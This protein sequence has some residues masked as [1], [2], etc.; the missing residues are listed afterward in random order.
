MTKKSS[1]IQIII[2]TAFICVL[3]VLNLILPDVEFSEQEN[4][5]LAQ[6][7][8]FSFSA[9]FSGKFMDKFESY[10]T[11]QFAF[12]DSWTTMKAGCE[13]A[14]GKKENKGVYLCSDGSLIERYTAPDKGLLETNIS[15]VHS[16]AESSGV[17]VYFALIPGA[18]EIRSEVLPKFAPN[19][20]QGA[21]IAYCYENSGAN[22]ID[23]V[24]KMSAHS[25]EYTYYRTDHH[26][27][28]L[29]AFYALET[30]LEGLGEKTYSLSDFTPETV[31]DAFY[32]TVY[33]KSG[34]SWV[35]PDSMDIFTPQDESTQ[36]FNY[37]SGEAE[38]GTMY[39]MEYLDKKDKYSMFMGGITPLAVVKTGISDADSILI[40]R[41]SYTDSLVPFLQQSFSEIHL[42]D[43]RYYKNQLLAGSVHDYVKDNN[44]DKVLICYSMSNFGT[45]TN[46]SLLAQ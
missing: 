31:S 43:L 39:D 46:I 19:Y 42:M 41:D 10:T 24:D 40:I 13:L 5:E 15:S 12:R 14:L 34:F 27:T 18:S 17:P 8:E 4:R 28:S 3:F 16:F 20:S 25:N 36:V 44:I 32:G 9:L 35:K 37:V 23:L 33:S 22:N 6:R 38:T 1:L 45:D 26:W 21:A 30:I 7:P 11:D 29:G 2:F